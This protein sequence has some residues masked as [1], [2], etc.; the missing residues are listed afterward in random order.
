MKA[1][2]KRTKRHIKRIAASMAAAF[3]ILVTSLPAAVF[4]EG[5]FN[6]GTFSPGTFSPGQFNPG[7]FDPGTFSPG[8]FDPGT[9]DPGTFS[10]GQFDPGKFSPGQFSPGDFQPGEFDPGEFDPGNTDP[11]SA[12]PGNANPGSTN[13]GNTNPGSTNP[14]NSG[15]GGTFPVNP[16]FKPLPGQNPFFPGNGGLPGLN[17]GQYPGQFPGYYPGLTTGPGNASNSDP[18]SG[19]PYNYVTDPWYKTTKVIGKNILMGSINE[20]ATTA[21]PYWFNWPAEWRKNTVNQM[22]WGKVSKK[23]FIAAVSGTITGKDEGSQNALMMFDAYS[24]YDNYK[25]ARGWFQSSDQIKNAWNMAK[26]TDTAN[27][28]LRGASNLKS[29][30]NTAKNIYGGI[31]KLPDSLTTGLGGKITPWTA[32]ASGVISAGEAF[33]NFK[34]GETTKG[35]ANIGEVL[36]S[37]SVVAAATGVGA[38]IAAG[39]A[40]AGGVIWA[41]A[42]IYQHRKAIGRFIKNPVKET[43]K[44]AEAIVKSTKKAAKAV[45]DGLSKVGDTISGWFN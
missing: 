36:M 13:P 28:T 23:S 44:A 40:V 39:M 31:T 19:E 42:K 35:I 7:T 21:S 45:K 30:L 25:T 2:R 43:K 1:M 37:G 34:N 16:P 29:N 9:F 27:D 5:K 14:G 20:F 10:P 18:G 12:N 15:P 11:G 38:P 22:D 6:P 17:P 32:A 33:S 3:I 4:A 26:A 24:G 41:G 8:Q